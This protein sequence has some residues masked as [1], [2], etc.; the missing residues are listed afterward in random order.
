MLI[1]L[2]ACLLIVA[3]MIMAL[4]GL[5]ASPL[6]ILQHLLAPEKTEQAIM[7]QGVR[8]KRV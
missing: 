3:T 5:L 6:S 8:L 2:R 7:W 4:H 1:C